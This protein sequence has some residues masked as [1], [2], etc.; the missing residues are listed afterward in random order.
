MRCQHDGCTCDVTEGEGFCS[1][2]CRDHGADMAHE[3]HGC[4]CGHPACQG[5]GLSAGG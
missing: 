4:D 3:Q 1:Q 2:T 5:A